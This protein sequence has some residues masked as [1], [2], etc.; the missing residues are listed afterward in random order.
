MMI[1]MSPEVTAG[2]IGLIG[3]G[4]G[5]ALTMVGAYIQQRTQAKIARQERHEVQGLESGKQALNS[6][7]T[8]RRML[9]E[10]MDRSREDP[11]D[12]GPLLVEAEL[13]VALI[14]NAA[15]RDRMGTV[16]RTI[17]A[18]WARGAVRTSARQLWKMNTAAEGIDLLSAY[19]RGDPLPASSSWFVV[20]RSKVVAEEH[21]RTELEAQPGEGSSEPS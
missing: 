19:L 9:A 16:F 8:F 6:L 3:V 18:R 11:W 7:I 21:R 17:N 1:G 5:A 4:V 13:S 12:E 14:P 20:A 10:E 15:L 2:W